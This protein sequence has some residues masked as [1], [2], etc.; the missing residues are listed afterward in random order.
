M[1]A[2][3]TGL[4]Q[5]YI[6]CNAG[7]DVGPARCFTAKLTTL[8]LQLTLV[9]GQD[10]HAKMQVEDVILIAHSAPAS[11]SQRLGS[12]SLQASS[13]DLTLAAVSLTAHSTGMLKSQ[14]LLYHYVDDAASYCVPR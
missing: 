14:R 6:C 1:Y 13:M 7:T 11:S 3:H 4:P 9:S 12:G 2:T 5:L 10:Q 8:G